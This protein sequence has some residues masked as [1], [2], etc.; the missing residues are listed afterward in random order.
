MVAMLA[1]AM[2]MVAGSSRDWTADHR[3]LTGEEYATCGP[4]PSWACGPEARIC[5]SD[6]SYEFGNNV[7]AAAEDRLAKV[8]FD[9]VALQAL[10]SRAA[11]M[12]TACGKT[13]CRILA[14][15]GGEISGAAVLGDRATG[16]GGGG[17]T[18]RDVQ[19]RMDSH[20]RVERPER[21]G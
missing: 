2:P 16:G 18:A 20:R 5:V 19:G 21:L 7:Y 4:R 9:A 14:G 1:M 10:A 11:L 15:C 12:A 6:E 17:S 3:L 8:V 13:C